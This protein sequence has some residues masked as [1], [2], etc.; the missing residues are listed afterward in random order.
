MRYV[1]YTLLEHKKKQK[2]KKKTKELRENFR[3]RIEYGRNC[4]EHVDWMSSDRIFF[5]I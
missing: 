2:T 5:L 4:K 3:I 1:G